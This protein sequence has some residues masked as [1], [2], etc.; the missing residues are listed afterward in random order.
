MK[1]YHCND[2]R[3]IMKETDNTFEVCEEGRGFIAAFP[4]TQYVEFKED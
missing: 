4:K 3:F 2:I 1:Y